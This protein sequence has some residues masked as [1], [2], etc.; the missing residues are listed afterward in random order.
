MATTSR[1]KIRLSIKFCLILLSLAG[2]SVFIL[3]KIYE[4]LPPTYWV[5]IER[6][7][8]N[9]NDFWASFIVEK[10]RVEI[11]F[12]TDGEL[13]IVIPNAKVLRRDVSKIVAYYEIAVSPEER[14]KLWK[15]ELSHD[16]RIG[17]IGGVEFGYY[18]TRNRDKKQQQET[19]Q[20]S[21]L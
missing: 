4:G 7:T 14:L 18:K 1:F 21:P 11:F 6:Q 9:S 17:I 5:C 15:A 2:L 16:L 3:V 8:C 12:E 10:D 19:Y 20:F 13:K